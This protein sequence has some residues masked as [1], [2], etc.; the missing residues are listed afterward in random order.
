MK[1][2]QRRQE[3]SLLIQNDINDSSSTI[4]KVSEKKK[5]SKRRIHFFN[6]VAVRPSLHLQNMTDDEVANTWYSEEETRQMKKDISNDL[7]KMLFIGVGSTIGSNE[8][9]SRGLEIRTRDGRKK[10]SANKLNST[11]AVLDE[12]DR[13]HDYGTNDSEVIRQVYFQQSSHCSIEAHN[14]ARNDE[15]EAVLIYNEFHKDIYLDDELRLMSSFV[16]KSISG[17][18]SRIIRG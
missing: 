7:K 18:A 17:L 10:R 16:K 4:L 5:S 11:D 9:T 2:L 1:V 8:F 6:C 3:P 12:Q 13:Q 14:L 15:A